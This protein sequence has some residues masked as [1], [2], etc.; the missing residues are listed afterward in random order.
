MSHHILIFKQTYLWLLCNTRIDPNKY[1]IPLFINYDMLLLQ[2][3][4]FPM[5]INYKT[6]PPTKILKTAHYWFI[7]CKVIVILILMNIKVKIEELYWQYR[8]SAPQRR[9]LSGVEV[10]CSLQSPVGRSWPSSLGSG[11][12]RTSFKWH[13]TSAEWQTHR[14]KVS[15]KIRG[16]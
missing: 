7:N 11:A 9:H 6:L 16:I 2:N 13:L 1:L 4:V 14:L 8:Q 5:A 3:M 12:G 10:A 15:T